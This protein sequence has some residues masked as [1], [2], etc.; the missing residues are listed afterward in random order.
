MIF[1]DHDVLDDWNTSASWRRDMQATSWWQ[2]R[3]CGALASYW[4]YQH[5]GNLSPAALATDQLYAAVRTDDDAA[6]RL[7]AFARRADR[8]ADGGPGTMW[9]YRRDF[10]PVRLLVIDSRCG[11]VLTEGRRSM[12]SDREFSWI[13]R[14]VEDGDFDHLIIGTSLPWLL[15]RALHDIESFDEALCRGV[16]G[17][18]LASFGEHLRRAVDLE[19]WA[20][21]RASFDRLARLCR[22]I[23]TG[24]PGDDRRRRSACC[25]ATC[26]TP[27]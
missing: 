6:E 19:H 12:V 7:R 27:M 2:E 9:S 17:R 21:F 25:R 23:A 4:I 26:T 8:E 3:I 24:G 22:T 11:R 1:D 14:Q 13:E 20:A 18:L 10:G 15:P 16:R 5:L